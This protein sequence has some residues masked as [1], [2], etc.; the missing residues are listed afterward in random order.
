M[1]RVIN[2]KKDLPN[3][4]YAVVMLDKEIDWAKKEDI[5]VLIVIHGYGSKGVGGLIKKAVLSELKIL[6]AKKEIIDFSLGD[7][8]GETSELKEKLNKLYPE[9]ILNEHLQNLNSGIS[10]VWLKK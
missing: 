2:I 4:D 9:T 1:L 6:K 10:V 3:C 8:F 5:N 7:H